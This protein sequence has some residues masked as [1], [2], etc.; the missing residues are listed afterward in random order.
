M[1]EDR[2][3]DRHR[4]T[5]EYDVIVIGGGPV[6]ENVAQYAVQGTSRTAAIV[7]QH[8]LGGECSYYACMPS[9][10]LLRPI[11]V[12]AAAAHLGGI[13][14]PTL[15]A[16]GLMERRDTWV[17]HYRD[18]GQVRWAE[19]EGLTVVRGRGRLV[20]ERA[21]E[22]TGPDGVRT[23][24]AREAV[25]L[26][27]GST[28]VLPPELAEVSPW[29][30]RD[31]TGVREVPSTL[32]IVGGGVVACEAARW[33]QAMGSRVTLLVRDTRVLARTE[34]F[35]GELVLEGLR[36]AGV[37]VR[38]GVSVVEAGRTD[39]YVDPGS[40]R[41]TA[42]RSGSGSTTARRR[43]TPRCWWRPGAG[44]RPRTSGWRRSASTRGSRSCRRGCTRSA[45]SRARRR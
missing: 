8:L 31:A 29:T 3:Q 12:A 7:E 13:S 6:G 41:C 35:A 25:V 23:L 26:A 17:S 4:D 36:A 10:A 39:V 42:A 37:E 28:P 27:T 16:A 40:G 11:E 32:A 18:G 38:L 19:G 34:P 15:D 22:V 44:R 20:G 9:K 14:A 30:S 1:A 45:T 43:R 33:M 21:V 5:D 2:H 24:R